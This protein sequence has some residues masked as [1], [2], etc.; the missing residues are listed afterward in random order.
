MN[1]LDLPDQQSGKE[2]VLAV[3]GTY[4]RRRVCWLFVFVWN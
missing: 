2:T 4:Q 1:G 3:S